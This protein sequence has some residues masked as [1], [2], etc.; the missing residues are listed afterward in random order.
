M[1]FCARLAVVVLFACLAAAAQDTGPP[2]AQGA[3]IPGLSSL[4][5]GL[6]GPGYVEVG[7]SY[8]N[9]YPA[10]Y[11]DWKDG[12]IRGVISGG[13]N[14]VNA[15]ITRENRFSDTGWFGSLGWTRTLSENVYVNASAGGSAGG[16]F[17]P[18]YRA[19]AELNI[20][21]LPSRQLVLNV[22]FGYDR[23]KTVNTAQRFLAG[24]TWY[25]TRG[26]IVQGGAT[27][28]R[29]NPGGYN[30]PAEFLTITQGHEKEHYISVR[31]DIGKEGYVEVG[32]QTT[33]VNFDLRQ[34]T[35]TWR[36]WVGVDWGFNLVAN[37]EDNPFYRR[38]GGSLG[39]FLEF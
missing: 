14:T 5:F 15:E 33:L 12:Y 24:A 1:N 16:F 34:Y 23:S 28:T 39:I 27:V 3:S 10:P 37:H 31:A 9:M 13:R 18:K 21:T 11:T 38:N 19:D 7:G 26:F 20:K 2:L 29:A 30:A 35:I 8:F 32:P 22:G 25:T 17:L 6:N 36:Q 4:P